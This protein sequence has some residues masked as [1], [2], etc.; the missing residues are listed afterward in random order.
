MVSGPPKRSDASMPV[1]ASGEN[2]ARSSM[3]DAHLVV[4]VDVV[5]GE[6]HQPG[7]GRGRGVEVLADAALELVDAAR[8][9][10]EAAGQAA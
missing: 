5:G 10:E 8:L 4:P 6:R 7:L 3:R 9:A 1:S 2:A